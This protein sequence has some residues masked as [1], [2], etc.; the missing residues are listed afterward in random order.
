MAL[1]TIETPKYEVKIP[2]TGKRIQYRPYLV[3]EE[4]ILM[5]AMESNDQ[6]QIIEAIK[7]VI[8][9][10]TFDKVDPDKLATFD[11]EY[12]FLKLRAKSV[13]EVSKVGLICEKCT[14]ST[15]VDINL[16]TI[17]INMASV[18]SNKIQ[19]TDKIGVT[20]CW[21]KIKTLNK[22]TGTQENTRID[23][24]ME[25]IAGCIE[26]ISDDKKLYP[27]SEHSKEELMQFLESLNQAQFAKIQQFIEATPRLEHTI[28]F[29][30]S[31]KDCKCKNSMVLSGIQSFFG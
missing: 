26:S 19:L 3:K 7:D 10:C 21:P 8:K 15:T 17:E 16:D 11:L 9:A 4:K 20:L 22:I 2:S 6:A 29:D 27:A 23:N 31:N 13:G 24:V 5:I 12:I 28:E 30:C 25:I 14:K 18:P 1:P